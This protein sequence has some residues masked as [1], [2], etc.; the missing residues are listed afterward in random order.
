MATVI[1]NT[2][3]NLQFVNTAPDLS[4]DDV[5]TLTIQAGEWEVQDH[6]E[7]GIV[8]DVSGATT[9]MLTAQD[10]RKLSKWLSRAADLID[11]AP[12]PKKKNKRRRYLEDDEEEDILNRY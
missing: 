3:N 2:T 9:P 1:I 8:F 5:P 11:D 10:A 4:T 12:A 7:P 6:V